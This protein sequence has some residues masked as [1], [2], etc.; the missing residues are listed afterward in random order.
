MAHLDFLSRNP[1]PDPKLSNV[2]KVIE[3]RVELADITDNWLRNSVEM[4]KFLNW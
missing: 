3:V 4:K 1:L 2:A